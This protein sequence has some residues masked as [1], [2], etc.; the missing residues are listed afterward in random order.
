MKTTK[1]TVWFYNTDD[2]LRKVEWS[3]L[4]ELIQTI[5]SEDDDI[6]IYAPSLDYEIVAI[7]GIDIEENINTFDDLYNW[8]MN[9]K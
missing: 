4:D 2:E 5:D 6:A 7:D 1:F 3:S 9:T 8:Y